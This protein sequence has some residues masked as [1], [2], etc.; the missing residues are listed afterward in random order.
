MYL[1]NLT[2]ATTMN[3]DQNEFKRI[4]ARERKNSQT[5]G[6]SRSSLMVIV[7]SLYFER[8]S[9][10]RRSE[11]VESS[12]AIFFCRMTSS[13]LFSLS[14]IS[15]FIKLQR[16]DELGLPI[17]SGVSKIKFHTPKQHPP[18]HDITFLVLQFTQVGF[19]LFTKYFLGPQ[20]LS[21]HTQLNL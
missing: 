13:R 8:S 7:G 16:K 2:E 15:E 1:V 6:D 10:A 3:I 19:D 14:S 18:N 5:Q 21:L 11:F 12:I 4:I 17:I 9:C 20:S